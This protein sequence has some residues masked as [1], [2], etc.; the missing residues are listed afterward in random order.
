LYVY[1]TY[2]LNHLQLT[3]LQSPVL[4]PAFSAIGVTLTFT[5]VC[6]GPVAS[7]LV[8]QM[9]SP[10]LRP[11][12]ASLEHSVHLIGICLNEISNVSLEESKKQVQLISEWLLMPLDVPLPLEGEFLKQFVCTDSIT[13]S[14]PTS[15]SI[16]FNCQ[17]TGS[18]I[19]S[20]LVIDIPSNMETEGIGLN[21][22]IIQTNRAQVLSPKTEKGESAASFKEIPE[23]VSGAIPQFLIFFF[24]HVFLC[25][26]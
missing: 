12:A 2:E 7:E 13:P 24:I 4:L 6:T 1:V 19:T 14:P 25:C 26:R 9:V 11:F 16:I 21:A 8:L 22:S 23:L 5:P 18:D 10:I 20:A 3:Y 17:K 15:H